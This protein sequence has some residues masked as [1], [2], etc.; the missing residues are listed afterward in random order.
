MVFKKTNLCA[1]VVLSALVFVG[2]GSDSGTPKGDDKGKDTGD[3]QDAGKEN[4]TG[5][6]SSEVDTS[7]KEQKTCDTLFDWAKDTCEMNSM[8]LV[9]VQLLCNN[10]DK[11]F[12]DDFMT[13]MID[14][15]MNKGCDELRELIQIPIGDTEVDTETAPPNAFQECMFEAADTAAPG[16]PNLEFKQHFCDYSIQCDPDI[17]NESDCEDLFQ[18][19][20]MGIF[21]A[22]DDPY[23]TNANECVDPMPSCDEDVQT[24][25]ELVGQDIVDAMFGDLMP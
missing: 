5:D 23:I 24:C 25:L 14:C 8:E 3:G 20:N 9:V 6:T 17:D 11:V 7:K 1:L 13:N 2:C 10:T 18:T 21:L 15:L 4:D 16:Q 19:E 12:I 22:V